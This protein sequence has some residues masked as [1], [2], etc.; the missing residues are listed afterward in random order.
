ML[1]YSEKASAMSDITICDPATAQE[2]ETGL[3]MELVDRQKAI[4]NARASCPVHPGD[5]HTTNSR[6]VLKLLAGPSYFTW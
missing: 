2:E 6:M 3:D 5:G 1:L 4:F